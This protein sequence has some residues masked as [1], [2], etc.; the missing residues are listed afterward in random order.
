MRVNEFSNV[1]NGHWNVSIDTSTNTLIIILK[2]V[3][4]LN[5]EIYEE[6]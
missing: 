3:F 1:T 4:F 5:N 6:K 2:N